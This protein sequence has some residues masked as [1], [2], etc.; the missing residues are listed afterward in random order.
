MRS[1]IMPPRDY[2]LSRIRHNERD[3]LPAAPYQRCAR[4]AKKKRSHGFRGSGHL[5]DWRKIS[6]ERGSLPPSPPPP[7][8][9]NL[10][11]APAHASRGCCMQPARIMAHVGLHV[12][13]CSARP[14]KH[15]SEVMRARL[16]VSRADGRR[17]SF[18]GVRVCMT[19]C[20]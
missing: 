15:N 3:Q 7:C 19:Y 1:L 18:L 5:F 16:G 12:G 10:R 6:L 20:K 13:C 9:C 11:P 8:I 14:S 2:I 4:R 17:S